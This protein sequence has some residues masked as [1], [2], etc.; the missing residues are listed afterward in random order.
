[1]KN[2]P[3]YPPLPMMN[4]MQSNWNEYFTIKY[5][6]SKMINAK[7]KIVELKY[8]PLQQVSPAH[9]IGV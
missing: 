6:L 8:I 4:E 1:M 7:H 3:N 9:I 5:H 2:E